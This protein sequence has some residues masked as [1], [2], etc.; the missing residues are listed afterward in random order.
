M[1]ISEIKKKDTES[2]AVLA[3]ELRESLRAFRFGGAGSR[4]R[5][6]KAG[7]SMR[8]DIARIETELTERSLA[9]KQ[10]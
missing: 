6:V 4:V 1:E 9:S 3:N 2:L 7:K 5:D 10:K 8:R